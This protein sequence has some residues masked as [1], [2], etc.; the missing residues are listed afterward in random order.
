MA[1]RD[2]IETEANAFA[3]ALLMPRKFLLAD[4]RQ[5]GGVDITDD[6]QVAKLAKKYKVSVSLMAVRIGQILAS[7]T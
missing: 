6:V 1:E 5:M 7:D 3:M 4:I 2:I